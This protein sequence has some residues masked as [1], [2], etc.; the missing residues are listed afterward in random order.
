M[1]R[2]QKYLA[3]EIRAYILVS[4]LIDGQTQLRDLGGIYVSYLSY[5][6]FERLDDGYTTECRLGMRFVTWCIIKLDCH[7][8]LFRAC[9]VLIVANYIS[10]PGIKMISWC[11]VFGDLTKTPDF[12]DHIQVNCLF[13]TREKSCSLKTT[14]SSKS[15]FLITGDQMY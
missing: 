11:W 6:P 4:R 1:I 10:H 12:S 9:H 13:S 8:T 14:R 5:I 2:R 3:K 7:V 15:A